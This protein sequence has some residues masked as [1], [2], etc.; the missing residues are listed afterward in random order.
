MP[1]Q[2]NNR[3]PF[4][5]FNANASIEF[6]KFRQSLKR[7][8]SFEAKPGFCR[9]CG[10]PSTS[11]CRS[12]TVPQ[13]SLKQ[14]AVDGFVLSAYG[15]ISPFD[16]AKTG[17]GKTATF[18][19]ICRNCDNTFFK[20]YENP[21][22]YI[23][24]PSQKMLGQIAAKIY[25]YAQDKVANELATYSITRRKY[26]YHS[27]YE[28]VR[29]TDRQENEA[30]LKRS[31]NCA[32]TGNGQ[33]ATIL[34]EKLDYVVPIAFQGKLDIISD[35][36]GHVINNLHARNTGY[37]IEPL[38]VCVFPLKSASAVI[39][40]HDKKAK[41]FKRFAKQLCS[42]NREERLCAVLKLILA[43][44]EEAYF[45][46][47]I[48]SDVLEDEHFRML[49]EMN[50]DETPYIHAMAKTRQTLIEVASNRYAVL[51]LPD[52]PNLLAPQYALR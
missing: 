15:I 46:P 17:L 11:F 3:P 22:A 39:V 48:S 52:I 37:R 29:N 8:A 2:A 31:I 14:I 27:P 43:Y 41:R 23:T 9:L 24:K 40:F 33:F 44:S 13:F 5:S 16:D 26:S 10:K 42:Q 21:D 7:E 32:K 47:S 34:F 1:E 28:P 12:H 18:N 50:I 30:Y 4:N 38:Y 45:S 36:E 49:L 25:L 35:F 51:N 19:T 20:D 6:N